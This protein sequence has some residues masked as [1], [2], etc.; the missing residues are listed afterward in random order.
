ME[1]AEQLIFEKIAVDRSRLTKD[2]APLAPDLLD[3][4]LSLE[5]TY[6]ELLDR[7]ENIESIKNDKVA[8]NELY[9]ACKQCVIFY[10]RIQVTC[11]VN[12]NAMYGALGAPF[13]RY[14]KR[15]VAADITAEGRNAIKML[16]KYTTKYFIEAWHKDTAFFEKM[17]QKYPRIILAD[18]L[19]PV[20]FKDGCVVYGDTD[21]LFFTLKNVIDSLGVPD[22]APTEMVT[23][24]IVDIMQGPINDMHKKALRQYAVS[25]NCKDIQV[26]EL[27]A[28]LRRGIFLAKKKYV[29]SYLWKDGKYIAKELKLKGTGIELS[30]KTTPM[31][32]KD[33]IKKYVYYMLASKKLDDAT[34]FEYSYAIQA[35]FVNIDIDKWSKSRGL[36]KFNKYH[37][38]NSKGI[39]VMEKGADLTAKGAIWYNNEVIARGLMQKYP[40]IKQGS[41]VKYYM[42]TTGETFSYPIDDDAEFPHEFAPMPDVRGN[43]K[44]LLFDPVSRILGKITTADLSLI[45]SDVTSKKVN[46]FTKRTAT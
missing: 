7:V 41:K 31:I 12:A 25:R 32:I 44:K 24:L 2:D 1:A 30:Q 14:Y 34:Y 6:K 4:R 21:S 38:I 18:K 26:F 36:G 13:F 37:S 11:K 46:P 22:N 8:L 33:V 19:V 20:Y 15:V 23:M 43:L 16:D 10:D 29:C 5:T 9:E 39:Y 35:K 45:G 40:L 27:E 42:T 17:K 28:V 3:A